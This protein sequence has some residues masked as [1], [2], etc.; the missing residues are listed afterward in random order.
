MYMYTKECQHLEVAEEPSG[1][2]EMAEW[3]RMGGW[4][5]EAAGRRR[6]PGVFLGELRARCWFQQGHKAG[7]FRD[8]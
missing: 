8:V 7:R 4:G 3:R 6:G 2:G 1:E 5:Q